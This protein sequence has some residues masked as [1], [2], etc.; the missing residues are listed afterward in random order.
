MGRRGSSDVQ[1]STFIWKS[2]LIGVGGGERCRLCFVWSWRCPSC[3]HFFICLRK[4]KKAIS[5]EFQTLSVLRP[6]AALTV[7]SVAFF[8]WF[9]GFSIWQLH[10]STIT[11][12]RHCWFNLKKCWI[13]TASICTK[14]VKIINIEK[15][16]NL[17]MQFYYFYLGI[18]CFLWDSLHY[19]GLTFS[20]DW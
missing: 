14:K 8:H 11:A 17:N 7:R 1:H 18:D 5:P 12:N 20:N 13:H 10:S 6:E 16:Q 3:K 4:E 19:P 9:C 2:F 15:E